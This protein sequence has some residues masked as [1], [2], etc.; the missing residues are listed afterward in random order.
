MTRTD[1][2]ATD[3]AI[4]SELQ[5]DGRLPYSQLGARVGLSEAASRQRVNRLTE[6]GVLSIVAVTDPIKLGYGYQ[7]ML[8]IT[9]H[10]TVAETADALA[11][12]EEVE[13]VVITAGHYNVIAEV[14][15]TDAEHFLRVIDEK[16]RAIEGIGTVETLTYL[17]LV[18]QTYNWGTM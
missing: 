1:L 4:I 8:G 9:V 6:R 12:I 18:K 15:C 14:L 7:A 3:K 10:T 11:E 2:D 5:N 16:I 13:Y 17:R